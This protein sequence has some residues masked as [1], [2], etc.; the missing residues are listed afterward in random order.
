MKKIT[1]IV[2]ALALVPL[3]AAS[4]KTPTKAE[5]REASQDCRAERDAAGVENF[6]ALYDRFGQCV[7]QTVR[8]NRAERRQ[9]R[10]EAA[11][12]CDA[13]DLEG[14]ERKE[15]MRSERKENLADA[16]AEDQ[17]ELNAAQDCRAEQDEIG[18]EAFA[19]QYGTNHNNRNAFGKCVS[20][21]VH[22]QETE[23]TESDDVEEETQPEDCVDSSEPQDTE[24]EDTE[25]DA[26]QSD[27]CEE[28]TDGD[29]TES[30]DSDE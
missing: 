4:A 17:L 27:D 23:E 15:C 22:A 5:K 3:P 13:Q 6:R 7:T 12:D 30:P 19:E 25:S 26:A 11:T 2:A 24:S 8:E 10:E 9:A 1:M 21:R 28:T 18:D 14:A 20:G 29:D 16:E